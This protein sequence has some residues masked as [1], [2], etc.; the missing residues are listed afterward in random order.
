MHVIAKEEVALEQLNKQLDTT[1]A[2]ADTEKKDILR[3]QSDLGQSKKTYQYASHTYT[4]DEVKQDLARHPM[5]RT[6][7]LRMHV[8][9]DTSP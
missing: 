3:L 1:Q 4:S 6:L 8:L 5:P 7:D 2:K 9:E